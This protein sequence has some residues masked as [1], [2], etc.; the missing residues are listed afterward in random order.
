MELNNPARLTF[1]S[2]RSP[3]WTRMLLFETG[4]KLASDT[5]IE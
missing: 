3:G 2:V 5:R 1:S 4:M